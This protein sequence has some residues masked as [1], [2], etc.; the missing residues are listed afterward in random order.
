MLHQLPNP[1]LR[2]LNTTLLN[3]LRC[4]GAMQLCC[5]RALEYL[6]QYHVP[7]RFSNAFDIQDWGNFGGEL[8]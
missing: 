6:T 4:L 5:D 7:S 1:I 8:C 3:A 2:D